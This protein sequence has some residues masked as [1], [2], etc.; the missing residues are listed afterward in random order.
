[1]AEQS[2]IEANKLLHDSYKH[3]T[4]LSTGAILI[5]A[6][7]LEKFFQNPKWKF[8]IGIT[9]VSFVISTVASVIAMFGISDD[10]E[11]DNLFSDL[12]ARSIIILS[13][14]SFLLGIL[15][16]VVFSLKNFFS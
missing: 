9:F 7:F 14:M 11:G 2:L 15:S 8:L 10:I 4:T 5:L 1:M 6:T 3:L 13:S 12:I 16:L